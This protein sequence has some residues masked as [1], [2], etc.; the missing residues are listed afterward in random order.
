[1]QNAGYASQDLI[2]PILQDSSGGRAATTLGNLFMLADASFLSA[3]KLTHMQSPVQPS[4]GHSIHERMERVPS[5]ART[6]LTDRFRLT[7]TRILVL[8]RRCTKNAHTAAGD[9]STTVAVR[10]AMMAENF[11]MLCVVFLD[12]SGSNDVWSIGG[13]SFSGATE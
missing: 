3:D 5:S 7:Y 13:R 11:M 4:Q 12:G 8:H 1:M 9:A 2:P 6:S 10:R